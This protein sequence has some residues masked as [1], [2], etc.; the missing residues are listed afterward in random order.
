[1]FYAEK[2]NRDFNQKVLKLQNRIK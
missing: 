1:M 2:T